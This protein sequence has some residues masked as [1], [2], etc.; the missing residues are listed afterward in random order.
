MDSRMHKFS[1]VTSFLI[2][3]ALWRM[4]SHAIYPEYIMHANALLILKKTLLP[5]EEESGYNT[6]SGRNATNVN[7]LN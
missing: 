5:T 2:A 6:F 4:Y 3:S 1:R 7:H